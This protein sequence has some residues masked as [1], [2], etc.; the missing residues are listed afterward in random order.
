MAFEHAQATALLDIPQAHGA[1]VPSRQRSAFIGAPHEFSDRVGVVL[2]EDLQA[3]S[4]LNL[5]EADVIR[6]GKDSAI[7]RAPQDA[8]DVVGVARKEAIGA[9]GPKFPQP[10]RAIA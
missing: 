8:V 2:V 10:D 7:V 4:A 1:I 5:P 3:M 9:S 6:T